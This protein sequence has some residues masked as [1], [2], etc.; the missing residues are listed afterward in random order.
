MMIKE[1]IDKENGKKWEIYRKS[2][3]EYF[4]KYYEY[5]SSIGW[6]FLFQDGGH[7]Q[8]FY[9]TKEIIECDFDIKIA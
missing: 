6:K 7:A 1:I 5:Y 8:G 2:E 9:Y 3:N 4:T